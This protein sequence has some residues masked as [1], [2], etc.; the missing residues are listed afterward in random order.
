MRTDIYYWKCDSPLPVEEKLTY[1]DKYRLA[2]IAPLAGR[3]AERHFGAAPL[4]VESTGSAGNHYAYRVRYPDRSYFFRAD[5]GRMEDDYMVAEGLAMELARGEGVPVPR[6]FVTDVTKEFLP[7]RYQ[8]IEWLEEPPLRRY[9]QEGTLD[10]AAVGRQLGR[11]VAQWHRVRLD[12]FGFLNTEELRRSG[13]AVGLDGSNRAYFR[14]RLDHH[15]RYLR[16]A[17]FLSA[18]TISEIESLI[19]RHDALLELPR[20]SMLHK[21]IAFWNLLGAPDRITAVIDWDDVVIGDPVDDIAILKCFYNEEVLRPFLAG[22]REV[23]PLPDAFEA[24]LSLYLLRN[25]LW[26]AVIRLFM[27]YFDMTGSFFILG[28]ENRRSL[29]QF[30]LDRI[31]EAMEGLRRA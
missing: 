3:A 13:R 18:G 20:G 23:A 5:D 8:L 2:D 25:M 19:A 4:A 11:H 26:K 9:D 29:R 31:A 17:E 28:P 12:G 22:Y 24:K 6:V 27:K 30:T 15:L 1:N 10:R 7:V 14:K 21:D 16:D